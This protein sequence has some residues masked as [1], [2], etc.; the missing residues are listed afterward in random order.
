MKRPLTAREKQLI[1]AAIIHIENSFYN[2]KAETAE[3][4]KEI[5]GKR[6]EY[7]KIYDAIQKREIL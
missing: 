6:N 2:I 7:N 5:E 1:E 3:R 4:K